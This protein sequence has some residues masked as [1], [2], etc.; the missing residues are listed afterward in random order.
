MRND[1]FQVVV[2]YM[3]TRRGVGLE[4]GFG[5]WPS[6]EQYAM[7]HVERA[8][9]RYSDACEEWHRVQANNAFP[10][11]V[12][13]AWQIEGVVFFQRAMD[14]AMEDLRAAELELQRVVSDEV[15]R[16]VDTLGER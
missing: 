14:E 10:P 3:H 9:R 4:I 8:Q 11:T 15:E 13:Q 7:G 2:R 12:A 5:D 1:A 6:L 16:M